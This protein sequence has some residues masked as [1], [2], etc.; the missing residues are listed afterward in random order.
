MPDAASRVYAAEMAL[1]LQH[2]H[3]H[4]IIFRDLKPEVWDAFMRVCLWRLGVVGG[5]MEGGQ[6]QQVDRWTCPSSLPLPAS[7][8]YKTRHYYA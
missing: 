5:R 2:L 1:A 8:P 6:M 4:G 3:D 7:H